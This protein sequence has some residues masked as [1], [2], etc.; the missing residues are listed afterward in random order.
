[1]SRSSARR[2]AEMIG[3][4]EKE[5]PRIGTTATV[6]SNGR[7]SINY[8]T[9]TERRFVVSKEQIM[10][11]PNLRG[12]WKYSDSVV[13]FRIKPVDRPRVALAFMPREAH[14]V[15]LPEEPACPRVERPAER[16]LELPMRE[17]TPPTYS[18][19]LEQAEIAISQ[20]VTPEIPPGPEFNY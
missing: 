13:R 12:Y 15:T 18:K 6:Q 8:S 2:V 14:F 20:E 1:M 3:E 5:R 11:L 17:S 16:Q 9:V 10:A 4:E 7:D 19:D